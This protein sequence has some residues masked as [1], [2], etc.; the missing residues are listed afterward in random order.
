M[1]R[2]PMVLAKGIV[3]DPGILN[4]TPVIEGTSVPALH[5]SSQ[6]F[7]GVPV[8]S[9]LPDYPGLT[10]Q[11][12]DVKDPQDASVVGTG[13]IV[14]PQ[15]GV[16]KR[17]ADHF[18]AEAKKLRK[19]NEHTKHALYMIQLA[20]NDAMASDNSSLE[21]YSDEQKFVLDRWPDAQ[22]VSLSDMFIVLSKSHGCATGLYYS[23]SKA[24]SAAAHVL[25]WIHEHGA[26]REKQ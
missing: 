21:E 11:S 6:A 19:E 12:I 1:G 5:I 13:A 22:C 17:R 3:S 4:G 2:I 10:A 25:T 26:I 23:A 15:E 18:M 7:A 24:W 14:E 20:L 9:I 8:E 16:W